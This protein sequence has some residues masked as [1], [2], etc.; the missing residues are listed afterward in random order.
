MRDDGVFAPHWPEAADVESGVCVGVGEF[1]GC[2]GAVFDGVGGAA[3]WD[4]GVASD[5]YWA[6]C[7]DV[8]VLG[9]V[10]EGGEEE[11]VGLDLGEGSEVSWWGDW[12]GLGG[13]LGK[14]E[15]RECCFWF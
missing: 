12:V 11:G 15:G 2:G 5:L 13:K 3:G 8:G 6:F 9:G 10:G 7:G 14:K 4:L 1:G